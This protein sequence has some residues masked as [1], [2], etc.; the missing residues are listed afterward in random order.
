MAGSESPLVLSAPFTPWVP[1]T[2]TSVATT[3]KA[4]GGIVESPVPSLSL[5]K[6]VDAE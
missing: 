6:L 1:Q 4:F 3:S 5:V 2:E